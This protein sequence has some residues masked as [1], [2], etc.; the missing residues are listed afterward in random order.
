MRVVGGCLALQDDTAFA[1]GL[2]EA[3]TTF[4]VDHN[5]QQKFSS[6]WCPIRRSVRFYEA[7]AHVEA[8]SSL[9]AA[10]Y[11]C[12]IGVYIYIYKYCNMN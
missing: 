4:V 7:A 8:H 3:A 9:I 2:F 5:L 12:H 1:L 6:C 10:F 11:G